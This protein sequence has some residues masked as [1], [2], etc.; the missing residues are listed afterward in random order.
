MAQWPAFLRGM[1]RNLLILGVLSR[2][3]RFVA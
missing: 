2:P 1:A 3:A